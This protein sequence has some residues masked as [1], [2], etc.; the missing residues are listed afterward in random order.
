MISQVQKTDTKGFN[1]LCTFAHIMS[2]ASL[3]T[4]D[5][6]SVFTND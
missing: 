1:I 2:D 5:I 6:A 4:Q 3:E